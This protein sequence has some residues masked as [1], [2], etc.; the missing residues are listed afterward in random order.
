MANERP[1]SAN[2]AAPESDAG[3]FKSWLNARLDSLDV[4]REVYGAYI[5][6]ILQE[7]D[8]DEEKKDALLGIF[9]AFL[10]NTSSGVFTSAA[11]CLTPS[12]G[13]SGFTGFSISVRPSMLQLK[14]VELVKEPFC[15]I[16]NITHSFYDHNYS[17]C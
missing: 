6:G 4:D 12:G 10:V 16:Q 8:S 11:V 3:E 13:A 14:S 2:M 9:S 1:Q 7:E 15:P 17:W 5:L